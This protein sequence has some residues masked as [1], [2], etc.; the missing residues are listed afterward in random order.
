[1]KRRRHIIALARA[2]GANEV[3]P[4]HALVTPKF[5]RLARDIGM[6]VNIWTCDNVKWVER[7]RKLGISSVMTNDPAKLLSYRSSLKTDGQLAT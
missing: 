3:S 2:F 7:A 4:N 6:P 5:T 1:M